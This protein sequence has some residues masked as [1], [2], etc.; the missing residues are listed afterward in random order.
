M[1]QFSNQSRGR[2]A[3]LGGDKTHSISYNNEWNL[4][5]SN[6]FDLCSAITL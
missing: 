3:P 6:Q 2:R 5:T 1:A 4:Q